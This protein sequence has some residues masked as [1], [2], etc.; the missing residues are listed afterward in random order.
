ML[1]AFDAMTSNRVYRRA[2]G[3]RYA[4]N[5]LKRNAGTQFDPKVVDTFLETLGPE[6]KAEHDSPHS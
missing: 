2:P 5:E 6:D 1:D 4:L 3:Y